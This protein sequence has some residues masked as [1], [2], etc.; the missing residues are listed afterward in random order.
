MPTRVA[1]ELTT[2]QRVRVL[3]VGHLV[4]TEQQAELVVLSQGTQ[5]CLARGEERMAAIEA[6][7]L[8][9]SAVTAEI[10]DIL[11]VAKVGLRVLGGVGT[12]VR[13]AGYIATALGAI[14]IAVYMAT[15][16]GKTP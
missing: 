16:G 6:E 15:H 5:V 8:A 2:D 13:W 7:L 4:L 9:N 1:T 11:A 10:R 12:A 3:E 14:Y